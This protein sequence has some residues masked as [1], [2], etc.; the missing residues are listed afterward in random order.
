M[1]A[2]RR[3]LEYNHLHSTSSACQECKVLVK[4]YQTDMAA[5]TNY[6]RRFLLRSAIDLAII[7]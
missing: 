6:L 5:T 4:Y 1:G 7:F 2:S 3:R